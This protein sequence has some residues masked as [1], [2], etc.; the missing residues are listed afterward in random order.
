MDHLKLQRAQW[1]LHEQNITGK[2]PDSEFT[3]SLHEEEYL[4]GKL[5]RLVV[6]GHE[7]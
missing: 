5:N 6:S 7:Y 2:L 1:D 4:V 3:A